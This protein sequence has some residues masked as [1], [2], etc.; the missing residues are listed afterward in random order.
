M[1]TSDS[2]PLLGADESEEELDPSASSSATPNQTHL[3]IQRE[4]PMFI[5]PAT[6]HMNK[7]LACY[8]SSC[9]TR[10]SDTSPWCNAWNERN[11]RGKG[12][13]VMIRNEGCYCFLTE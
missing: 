2:T 11:G 9:P 5:S 6:R 10:S 8:S 3:S 12:N 7:A 1:N 4:S 13:T